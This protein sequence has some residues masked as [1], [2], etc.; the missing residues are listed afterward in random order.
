MATPR[1]TAI[2]YIE[3]GA[4]KRPVKVEDIQK[5]VKTVE[6]RKSAY[7]NAA[8]AAVYVVDGDGKSTKVDL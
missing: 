2:I 8:E 1:K 7:V 5:A 4:D 3:V 6:G